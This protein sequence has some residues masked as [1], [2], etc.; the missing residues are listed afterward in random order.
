VKDLTGK[1]PDVL[2]QRLNV[3][4]IQWPGA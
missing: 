1:T 2:D 4:S 3:R